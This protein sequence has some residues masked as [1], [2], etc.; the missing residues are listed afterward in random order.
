MIEVKI[1]LITTPRFGQTYEHIQSLIK[2]KLDELADEIEGDYYH[3]Q[4]L[5]QQNFKGEE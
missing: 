5:I 1:D 3:T 2:R 4:F